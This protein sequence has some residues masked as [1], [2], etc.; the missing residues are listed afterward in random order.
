LAPAPTYTYDPSRLTF[1]RKELREGKKKLTIAAGPNNPVGSTWID[2][3]KDTFGIHGTPDP[4]LVGKRASNGCVRLTNWDAKAL[5]AAVKAGAT[6]VFTGK[7][8]SFEA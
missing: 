1:G 4:R 2:L 8:K 3:T 5:G 6:V 7:E